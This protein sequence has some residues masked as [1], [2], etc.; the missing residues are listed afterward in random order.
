M[1]CVAACASRWY[2]VPGGR[3]PILGRHGIDEAGM[4]DITET[5]KK[6][7]KRQEAIQDMAPQTPNKEVTLHLQTQHAA[8]GACAAILKDLKPELQPR[9]SKRPTEKELGELY[10]IEVAP[11]LV[12]LIEGAEELAEGKDHEVLKRTGW[13]VAF[14]AGKWITKLLPVRYEDVKDVVEAIGAI[15]DIRKLGSSL[16]ERKREAAAAAK[17]LQWSKNGAL[18]AMGW[19]T[20]AERILDLLSGAPDRTDNQ[21]LKAVQQRMKTAV[22][23]WK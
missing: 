2:L 13:R 3:S 22:S 8:I 10:G 5:L 11:T 9:G 14:V 23:E 18:I 1:D 4:K 15:A 20:E 12:S 19:G 7:K 21:R 17:V 16:K 6:L